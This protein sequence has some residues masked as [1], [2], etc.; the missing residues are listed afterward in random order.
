MER[1]VRFAFAASNN[2]AEYEALLSGLKICYEAGAKTLFAFS[3]SQLI[4]GQV[5]RE[6]EAKDNS[7][8]MYLQQ[9][10]KF[11]KKFDK[12]TLV[13]IPQDPKTHKPT[14]WKNLPA[15]L[16]HPRLVISSG[17]WFLTPASYSRS[18]Q[19]INQRR[20]WNHTSN[21]CKI[22]HFPKMSVEQN[23]SQRTPDGSNSTKE[24]S[25]KNHIHIPF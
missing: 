12:F 22:K 5:N 8:K 23:C 4:V 2:E 24:R 17:R 1:A 16:K 9:V 14:L 20:G 3:N 18:I 15:Q 7:M 11:I 13:H 19:S 25:T 6:F 21:T 10:T